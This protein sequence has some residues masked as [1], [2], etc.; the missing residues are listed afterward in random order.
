MQINGPVSANYDID[1]GAYPISDWYYSTSTLIHLQTE[2]VVGLPPPSDNILFNGTNINPRGS[3]GAYSRVKLTPGK[4]HLLRLINMSV[5]NSFIVSLVGHKF[6]VVATDLVPVQP[7]VK[8]QLFLGVGQRYDVIIDASQRVDS[9]WFNASLGAS[10]T[11]GRSANTQAAAIFSYDGAGQGVPSDPGPAFPATCDETTGF[12]PVLI[13]D[14][15]RE[16]FMA[17]EH[18]LDVDLSSTVISRGNVYRWTVN[19]HMI[20]VQW[21]KPR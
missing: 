8:D 4:K 14:A 2:Q 10:T 3:G 17:H 21:D 19:R 9:Y 12:T 15:S 5:E 16:E 20:D 6:I 1:L 11:C 7:V 13:R 18:M